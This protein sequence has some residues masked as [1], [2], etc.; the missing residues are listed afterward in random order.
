[1]RPFS[2]MLLVFVLLLWGCSNKTDSFVPPDLLYLFASYPVGK[3]PTSIKS[4]DF[5]QDGFTDLITTN[6]RSNS[7][8]ILMG[9]GDGS[10][11]AETT[12][13]VCKEPRNLAINRF[14]QDLFEDL[15]VACSGSGQVTIFLG[16]GNGQFD[17][18]GEYS[19]QRTPVSIATGDFNSDAVLDLVVALRNDKIQL[20]YG[21]GNG[22]FRKGP[23]Y[24][25]GDTPTSVITADFNRDGHSDLAVTNGGPMT[26]AVSIW[27]GQGDGTF[28]VPVDYRTGKRPL[29]VK[30]ADFNTDGIIDL[31]VINGQMNTITVFIGNGDGTFRDGKDSGGEAGPNDGLAQD[32][33]GDKIPDIAIVNI[34]SGSLSI[35]YGKGD[36][37]FQY[38]PVNYTTPRGPFAL[39]SL[40]VAEGR[41]ERPGLAI[42]NN[43]EHSVTIFLHHGLKTRASEHTSSAT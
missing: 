22:R 43:A 4:G 17:K 41:D 9:N 27:L 35:L 7:L 18:L 26:S 10:F 23:L 32:F 19:V 40:T 1:M 13:L 36:G 2:H 25:Y 33:N 8:S 12:M 20:L 38:P 24:V 11:T 3:N 37:T 21:S 16:K 28:L 42:A 31:L 14:N 5:N 29:S 30:L 6:I 39:I 34:Q 15:A